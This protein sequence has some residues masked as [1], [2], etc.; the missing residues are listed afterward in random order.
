MR[1]LPYNIYIPIVLTLKQEINLS[2]KDR[3]GNEI[4]D[5]LGVGKDENEKVYYKIIWR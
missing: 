1:K 3:A 2:Y 4:Q 5:G